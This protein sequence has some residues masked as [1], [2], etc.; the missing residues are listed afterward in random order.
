VIGKTFKRELAALAF[1][2]LAWQ[3]WENDYKMVEILVYPVF[4]YAALAFG[5]QWYAPNGGMFRVQSTRP[6]REWRGEYSGE[7]PNWQNQ[8]TD[9]RDYYNIREPYYSTKGPYDYAG[10]QQ[11]NDK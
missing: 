5:L 10:Q 6:A 2:M 1:A 7:Y 8:P 9:N 4:S 3:V 11:D